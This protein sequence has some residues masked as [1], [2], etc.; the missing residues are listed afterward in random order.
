MTMMSAT[1]A[2]DSAKSSLRP[3]SDVMLWPSGTASVLTTP[4]GVSSKAHAKISATGRPMSSSA[5]IV[6]SNHSGRPSD[7]SSAVATWTS[8]QPTTM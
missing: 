3:V 5:T 1:M 2:I 8:I 6:P 4:S 7:S